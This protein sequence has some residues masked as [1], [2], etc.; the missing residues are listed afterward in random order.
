[1]WQTHYW[2]VFL[3]WM[4]AKLLTQLNHNPKVLLK[5]W[6]WFTLWT[7]LRISSVTYICI[8]EERKS[9]R[10]FLSIV[11][12]K[13]VSKAAALVLINL[14]PILSG[15][16]SIF[17]LP[18]AESKL[19]KNT[20]LV[21]KEK[22]TPVFHKFL[23]PLLVNFPHIYSLNSIPESTSQ[24]LW[25]TFKFTATLNCK[26]LCLLDAQKHTICAVNDCSGN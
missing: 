11:N 6:Q 17:L 18:Y 2:M 9:I 3:F 20:M 25:V 5:G 21:Y 19:L 26:Y 7:K 12:S 16:Q 15:I 23:L 8:Y 22:Q 13:H 24:L 1:M 10:Q 14:V 4:I